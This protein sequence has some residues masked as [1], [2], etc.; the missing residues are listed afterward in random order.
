MNVTQLSVHPLHKSFR[1]PTAAPLKVPVLVEIVTGPSSATRPP[2]EV[3]LVLDFSGSM[4]GAKINNLKEAACFVIDTLRD[5]DVFTVVAYTDDSTVLAE[6][7]SGARAKEDLKV[8]LRRRSADGG[9][10]ISG[11]LELCAQL[12]ISHNDNEER[13]GRI[14]R[15]FLFSDGQPGTG[16]TRPEQFEPLMTSLKEQGL[17]VW[18]FGIGE[19]IN[20]ELMRSIAEYG[21]GHYDFV[22]MRR[23]EEMTRRAVSGLARMRGTRATLDVSFPISSVA[24]SSATV[25]FDASR[26]KALDS[27]GAE[28]SGS[29]VD[30]GDVRYESCRQ[31]L[32]IL[33]LPPPVRS[34]AVDEASPVNVHVANVKLSF[35]PAD[36]P[37]APYV[38]LSAQIFM[39]TSPQAPEDADSDPACAC[40]LAM[41]KS[42]GSFDRVA[43][44]LEQNQVLPAKAMLEET[45][46]ELA[47]YEGIDSTGFVETQLRRGRRLVQRL[48][49]GGASEA[50]RVVLDLNHQS[51][52]IDRM[53]GMDFQASETQSEPA[54]QRFAP[55]HSPRLP[56]GSSDGGSEDGEFVVFRTDSPTLSSPQG[57]HFPAPIAIPLTSIPP[58]MIIPSSFLCTISGELML[59][60]VFTTD[61]HTYDR[62][63]IQKWF[64]DGHFTSP[65][66]NLPL[67]ELT[68]RPNY[69]L[70]GLIEAWA[71]GLQP[72]ADPAA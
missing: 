10:N 1:Y 14:K 15:I 59:E 32:L 50:R 33:N 53:S 65:V 57:V 4:S 34:S 45:L 38:E 19:D 43:E 48:N 56:Q 9:T 5:D 47:K 62:A 68:L 17:S 28:L 39:I 37:L 54:V 26:C 8:A 6:S 49:V 44:L 27:T 2:F 11:A 30:V 72:A 3:G 40:C 63:S 22:T 31:V 52:M 55:Q 13:R 60:P 24:P 12:M 51:T 71:A 20:E 70:R 67:A 42:K 66:T 21:D 36:S 16:L 64:D 29:T 69:S 18:T 7:A 46:S 23:I 41:H 25:L 61:G 58:S 35:A